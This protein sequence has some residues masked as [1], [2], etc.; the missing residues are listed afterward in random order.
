M[1]DWRA[2]WQELEPPPW[3]AVLPLGSIEQ[4]GPFLPIG[5]D[6]IMAA[7]IGEA[8]ARELGAWLLPAQPYSCAQEHQEFPGTVTL[9][10]GT[11]AVLLADIATSVARAKVRHLAIINFHGGNWALKSIARDINRQQGGVIMHI[12]SPYEGVPGLAL[13]EDL[14]SG[15]FETSIWLHAY[16]ELVRPGRRDCVPSIAPA[17]LDQV[18]VR[19]V[20][21][22]GQWGRASQ[23]SAERGERDVAW[24]V[25]NAVQRIREAVAQVDALRGKEQES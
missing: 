25:E 5:A 4:H 20:S 1:L 6:W 12:F 16:P 11:L 2:T 21:P 10:P 24:M 18:G 15:D 9:R 7:H 17:L 22:E 19:S 3:L 8:I 14:H 23:A 13:G